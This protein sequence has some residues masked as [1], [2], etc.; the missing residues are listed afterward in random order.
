MEI[1][2]AVATL[3]RKIETTAQTY[4]P[5]IGA[6]NSRAKVNINLMLDRASH[7][8]SRSNLGVPWR[9]VVSCIR[10][11]DIITTTD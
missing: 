10:M 6:C 1:I 2:V 9:C 3:R 7:K 4:D 5:K 8:N 11:P